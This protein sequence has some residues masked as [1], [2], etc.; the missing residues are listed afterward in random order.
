M[1]SFLSKALKIEF[2]EK[3]KDILPAFEKVGTD[4]GGVI[5]RNSKASDRYN[6]FVFLSPSPKF[7]R[8]TIEFAAS[9]EREFPFTLLPGER[10]AE[11]TTRERIKRFLPKDRDGWWN[12]T[13]SH[14]PDLDKVI[15]AQAATE[16]EVSKV[17]PAV[18]DAF[19]YLSD[20]LTRFLTLVG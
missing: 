10:N 14:E 2:H 15:A 18:E 9:R 16:R 4:F 13:S 12:L 11:G 7:D 20:A 19:A 1:K 5:Y 3:M 17:K 8:F 6:V